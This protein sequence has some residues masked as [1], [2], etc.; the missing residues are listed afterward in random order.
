MAVFYK[1]CRTGWSSRVHNK[2][3]PVSAMDH[4]RSAAV[5]CTRL[6]QKRRETSLSILTFSPPESRHSR[7]SYNNYF[8]C[9]LYHWTSNLS[10]STCVSEVGPY[11]YKHVFLDPIVTS[12]K[13]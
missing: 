3:E 8:L 12:G 7:R 4:S 9:F 11:P 10:V 6:D 5:R 13:L 1:L 2:S